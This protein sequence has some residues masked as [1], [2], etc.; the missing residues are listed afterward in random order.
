MSLPALTIPD[1]ALTRKAMQ[2]ALKRIMD[3]LAAASLMLV[4]LPLLLLLA[5]LV[6]TRLGSPIFFTQTRIGMDLM[7]G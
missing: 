2:H 3:I 1:V 5:L 7:N 4:L 6:R